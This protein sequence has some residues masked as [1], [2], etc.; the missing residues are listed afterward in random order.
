MLHVEQMVDK[1]KRC[2]QE[3]DKY[4]RSKSGDSLLVLMERVGAAMV[5]QAHLVTLLILSEDCLRYQTWDGNKK[6]FI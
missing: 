3:A 5:G 2:V 1:Y 6:P 4:R